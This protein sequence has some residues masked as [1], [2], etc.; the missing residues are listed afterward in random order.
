MPQIVLTIWPLVSILIFLGLGPARGLIWSVVVGY[1]FLPE[2]TMNVSGLPGY[3]KLEAVSVGALLGTLLTMSR[4]EPR[5]KS[6]ALSQ[7][8]FLMLLLLMFLSPVLTVMFNTETLFFGPTMVKPLEPWDIQNISLPLLTAIVPWLLARRFLHSPEHHREILKAM[9][10]VGLFYSLLVLFELRMSPQIN[11][12]VYGF[13]PHSWTQ[14]LRGGGFRPLVFLRHGLWLGFFLMTVVL[15]AAAMTRVKGNMRA[16][17]LLSMVWMLLVLLVSRNLGAAA[18]GLILVPFALL[19]APRIQM[20]IAVI[21]AVLF[22]ANPLVRD[23]Y[24][25]PLLSMS[26]KISIHR[27]NSLRTRFDNESALL[28]RAAERP[29]IGWGNSS[30]WRVFD[31]RG[32]DVTLSDGT[33]IIILAQRGWFGFISF[34]GLLIVPILLF[35]RA[36]KSRSVTSETSVLALMVGANLVYLIPNSTLSPIGWLV[37]GALAGFVQ[38]KPSMKTTAEESGAA[39]QSQPVS[40]RPVYTRFGTGTPPEAVTRR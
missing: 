1:L 7:R 6:D 37:A 22:M 34:F 26:E 25:E 17:Y 11:N 39:D 13:F 3:G 16:F 24:M 20:R 18:I 30:R 19:A 27:A 31:E 32:R 21:L 28:D 35:R 5:P 9:I 40:R 38:F 36:A 33:W 29:V 14:H 8:L 12:M 10:L 15:A 23:S 2:L 4:A